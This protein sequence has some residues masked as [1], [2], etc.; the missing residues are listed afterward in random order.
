VCALID[1]T[2]RIEPRG[3]GRARHCET[4]WIGC[5]L[6]WCA[7]V[8]PMRHAPNELF[9]STRDEL[10]SGPG[11]RVRPATTESQEAHACRATR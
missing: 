6:E 9:N 2:R 4:K 11:T 7:S 3:S 1:A 5:F 8:S 10:R